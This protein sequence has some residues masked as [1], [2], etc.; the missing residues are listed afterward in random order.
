MC[1][2][3]TPALEVPTMWSV[4]FDQVAHKPDKTKKLYEIKFNIQ[5]ANI[6]PHP[7]ATENWS[8]RKKVSEAGIWPCPNAHSLTPGRGTLILGNFVFYFY[9]S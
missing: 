7:P 8:Y 2:A 1:Q 5:K 6:K 4:W 3:P 9:E